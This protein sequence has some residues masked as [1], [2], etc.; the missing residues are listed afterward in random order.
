[1]TQTT[2]TR[3]VARETHAFGMSSLLVND[4]V[5]G[6]VREERCEDVD[7]EHES[8]TDAGYECT[9]ENVDKFSRSGTNE[10]QSDDD[11]TR[12]TQSLESMAEKAEYNVEPIQNKVVAVSDPNT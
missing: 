1:M 3:S 7:K 10:E 4:P 6:S 11:D 8:L 5:T 9:S 12:Q 2:A